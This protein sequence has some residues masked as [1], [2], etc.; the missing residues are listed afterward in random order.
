MDEFCLQLYALL[1]A[2]L[3]ITIC[4]ASQNL[5]PLTAIDGAARA[6]AASQSARVIKAGSPQPTTIPG[7]DLAHCICEA[8]T[9]P[10]HGVVVDRRP[11]GQARQGLIPRRPVVVL[12]IGGTSSGGRETVAGQAVSFQ[13]RNRTRTDREQ[14]KETL[15]MIKESED[16]V[17]KRM[18][19]NRR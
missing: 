10:H 19:A 9:S 1:Y 16:G 14:S 5:P 7:V 12:Q 8:R 15:S 6:R 11:A 18:R 4:A 2:L 17:I 13:L 3:D